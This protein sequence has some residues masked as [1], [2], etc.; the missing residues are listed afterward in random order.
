MTTT[1]ALHSFRAGVGRTQLATNLAGVL[2]IG[3][4]QVG[5]VDFGDERFGVPALFGLD[6]RDLSERLH[7]YFWDRLP[8]EETPVDVTAQ[9]GQETP[10]GRLFV[11]PT[12]LWRE[13]L[14]PP[15]PAGVEPGL[16]Q[17]A[18]SRI[19]SGLA[20]D[21]LIVE[22]GSGL[23]DGALVSVASADILL[24]V[25]RPDAQDLQATAVMLGI[26]ERLGATRISLVVSQAPSSADPAALRRQFEAAYHVPVAAVL[27][28]TPELAHREPGVL[29]AL[30]RPG[31][32][33]S[34]AIHRLARRLATG[35]PAGQRLGSGEW[36]LS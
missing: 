11:I 6:S 30:H 8:L 28:L 9:L 16:F 3:G 15:V 31:H 29:L 27:P 23:D 25:A 13:W 17:M 32:P 14:T 36:T 18:I 4:A 12:I 10:S 21:W 5:I 35:D 7:A 34:R 33:W 19:A 2:A 1:L 26:A 24:E 22:T 20:L